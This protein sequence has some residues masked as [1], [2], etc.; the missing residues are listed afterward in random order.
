VRSNTTSL[1][2]SDV[3]T[4]NAGSGSKVGPGVGD[5]VIT[6]GDGVIGVGGGMINVVEG[7]IGAGFSVGEIT[8]CVTGCVGS[9]RVGFVTFE[10][11]ARSKASTTRMG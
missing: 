1:A 7:V 5:G 8:V 11:A 2:L 9:K 4:P 6:M 10:H 3:I